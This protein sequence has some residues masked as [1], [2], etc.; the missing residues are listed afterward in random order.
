MT[1]IKICGMT[2][3]EDALTAVEAGA[4]AVGFVF[5]EKSPRNI[6]VEAAREIVE[7]L[8]ES[9][10]KIG[11]FVNGSEPNPLDVLLD[12]GLTG[13]QNYFLGANGKEPVGGAKAIE[14]SLLPK[15]ARFL[16]ALPLNLLGDEEQVPT[17]EFDFT[18]WGKNLPEGISIPEG[19]MDT[20]VLDSGDLRM[21]G[22]TGKT[23]DWERAL[24]IAEAM[25]RGGVKLVV[26]GG[27]TAENVAEAIGIL[28]PWGVD[29][30]SGV[31][32]R[33]GK[34]DPEKVR[35]FVKAVREID[36]KT[37]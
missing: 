9:V 4:D 3:L 21:P 2:N 17:I 22:G 1:W 14:V 32:A 5:Y 35:A 16:M 30:A 15:R 28:K 8:P 18:R 6:G 29:V 36:R 25:R 12:A 26:A 37:S 31:E 19:L 11:V 10:E 27:L 24:P 20:F 34:K 23:F 7:K 13:T 33:P